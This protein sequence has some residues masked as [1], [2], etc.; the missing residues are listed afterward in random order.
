MKGDMSVF[1]LAFVA[2]ILGGAMLYGMV[3]SAIAEPMQFLMVVVMMVV[4]IGGTILFSNFE[5]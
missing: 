3:V 5:G 1:F 2:L 4:V